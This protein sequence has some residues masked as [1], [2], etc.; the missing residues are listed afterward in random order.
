MVCP[1]YNLAAGFNRGKT[2]LVVVAV[3]G[4][5]GGLGIAYRFHARGSRAF[6]LIREQVGVSGR[7]RFWTRGLGKVCV[8]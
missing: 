2:E 3:Q 1:L 6:R 8:A 7:G 4:A 5:L